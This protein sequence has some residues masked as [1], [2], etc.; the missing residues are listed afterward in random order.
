MNDHSTDISFDVERAY[1]RLTAMQSLVTEILGGFFHRSAEE[2][3]EAIDDAISRLGSFCGVDRTY[4]FSFHSKGRMSNTHEWCAESIT[5]EIENLQDIPTSLIEFWLPRLASGEPVEVPHI[6]LLSDDRK[7]EREL[8]EEQ[9][10]QSLL[11]VPMLNAGELFGFVGFDSVRSTRRFTDGERHLLT[12]I[13]DVICSALVRE[14][15]AQKVSDA[16]ARLEAIT[17]NTSDLVMVIDGAERISWASPSVARL[18]QRPMEGEEWS[19]VVDH[20]HKASVQKAAHSLLSQQETGASGNLPD[21]RVQTPVGERWLAIHLVDLHDTPAVNG[22]VVTARDITERRKAEDLITHQA[23]HDVLTGLP[24]RFLLSD[25]LLNAA[26]RAKRHE[27]KIGLLYV[28]VDH[29]KIVNDG[30]GHSIGDELLKIISARITNCIRSTDTVSRIGGDE[31]VVLVDQI[32]HDTDMDRI[33]EAIV[34]SISLPIEVR[35][36]K[37][38]VT[39]SIGS[40]VHGGQD[41]DLEKT[42]QNVDAA[43]YRAKKTGRSRVAKFTKEIQHESEFEAQVAHKL[44]NAIENQE[45]Y[46][47][48]QPI[49]SIHSQECVGYEALARW[50]DSELGFISPGSFIGIAER[51]GQIGELGLCVLKQA[52]DLAAQKPGSWFLNVN[53]SPQELDQ[54]VIESAVSQLLSSSSFPPSRLCL[55]MTENTIANQ[56]DETISMLNSL[57]DLGVRL[58]IDDFGTGY[59]SFGILRSIPFDFLKIDKSF[60]SGISQDGTNSRFVRAFLG[61]A[62]DLGLQVI[63]EGI[64]TIEQEH[65]LKELGCCLGQGFLFGRPGVLNPGFV[66]E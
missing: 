14:E 52:L 45:I 28:D 27:H 24:N 26:E 56:S 61:L 53:I 3:K 31:F 57:K 34:S 42:L 12:S 66:S 54:E 33:S 38:L 5:P 18:F 51:T 7:A 43:M 6:K 25:R 55:E 30:H 60:V 35:N 59:S 19:S 16:Q 41:F 44:H 2:I 58:A 64:E 21:C 37:F 20:Q 32:D 48:F 40:L 4:V 63:A 17:D 8:L 29:F 47:V 11:V 9:G 62:S 49:Y 36:K 1:K 65:A 22:V 15:A 46:P 13:A 23:T 10:I 39:A 50:F